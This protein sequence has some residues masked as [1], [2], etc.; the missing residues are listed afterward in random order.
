MSN[1]IIRVFEALGGR[2]EVTAEFDEYNLTRS[3]QERKA[4][5]ITTRYAKVAQQ[6]K[7]DFDHIVMSAGET[8]SAR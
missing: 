4:Y 2:F 3:A 6:L 8:Y 1:E 5:E 7:E